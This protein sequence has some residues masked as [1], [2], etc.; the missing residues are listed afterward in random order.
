MLQILKIKTQIDLAFV[1]SRERGQS[2]MNPRFFRKSWGSWLVCRPACWLPSGFLAERLGTQWKI[3]VCGSRYGAF[4]PR[5]A[6][7]TMLRQNLWWGIRRPRECFAASSHNSWARS[8]PAVRQYI[9]KNSVNRPEIIDVTFIE[10][11]YE[12]RQ[13]LAPKLDLSRGGVIEPTIFKIDAIEFCC[14]IWKYF[15][16]FWLICKNFNRWADR[17]N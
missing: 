2:R 3:L 7:T 13:Y 4:C 16:K 5:V 15:K 12:A 10:I 1:A 8:L 14:F 9:F 11:G 17:K 6:C